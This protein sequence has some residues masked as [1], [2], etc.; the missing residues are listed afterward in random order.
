MTPLTDT[1]QPWRGVLSSVPGQRPMHGDG[2]SDAIFDRIIPTRS[3]GFKYDTIVNSVTIVE[4]GKKTVHRPWNPISLNN[5]L[6]LWSFRPFNPG[7][8]HGLIYSALS[9]LGRTHLSLFVSKMS[10]FIASER[11]ISMSTFASGNKYVLTKLE[12]TAVLPNIALKKR[13]VWSLQPFSFHGKQ[14]K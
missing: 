5:W 2:I 12:T 1:Y 13:F 8:R 10:F 14:Y 6:F 7:L 3:V 11:L 9:G 4:P